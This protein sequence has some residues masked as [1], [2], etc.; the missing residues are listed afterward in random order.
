MPKNP[1]P[2]LISQAEYARH[3]KVN[4]SHIS[5]LAKAGVLVMRH[6][7]VDVAA[8]DAVLD[9]RPVA[10]EPSETVQTAQP[11]AGPETV[12]PQ[13]T[14]YAQ[15]RLAD[16]VYRA[17]L[18]RLEYEARSGK[19]ISA[20]EVKAKWFVVARQIRDKLLAIPVKLSPQLAALADAREVHE[21]LETE[22]TAILRALQDD[23]R[24]RRA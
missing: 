2:G 19:L 8:S 11:H 12:G 20:D 7:K 1:S 21:L 5:R 16:M 14:S 18:R 3:R 13:P 22:L 15:A 23:I 6:G 24:Y 17:K 9:D 4:R 10:V